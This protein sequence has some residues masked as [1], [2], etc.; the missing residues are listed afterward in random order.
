MERLSG[1]TC[2][3]YSNA[4]RG[5]HIGRAPGHDGCCTA[6]GCTLYMRGRP[7][8]G[9]AHP[10]R[11]KTRPSA[12]RLSLAVRRKHSTSRLRA[13]SRMWWHRVL[14]VRG[15][16][17]HIARRRN[18]VPKRTLLKI[19]LLSPCTPA[20]DVLRALSD[21][22][23]RCKTDRPADPKIRFHRLLTQLAKHLISSQAVERSRA[24]TVAA[25][26]ALHDF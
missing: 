1:G 11:V 12:C 15:G 2:Y 18:S 26:A 22:A 6:L 9:T 4:C 13:C 8:E 24:G 19:S 25:D 20:S 16:N 21:L 14:P 7:H 3:C 5:S 23:A 10:R 17:E